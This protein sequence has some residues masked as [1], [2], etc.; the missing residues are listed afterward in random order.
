LAS[1]YGQAGDVPELREPISAAVSMLLA[2]GAVQRAVTA[3]HFGWEPAKHASGHHWPPALLALLLDDPY[4]VV[5]YV[6]AKSLKSYPG[7]A[8]FEYDYIGPE[9]E[10]KQ[11]VDSALRQWRVIRPT[12]A[13]W[14]PAT[15]IDAGGELD[16]QR[17]RR[18][19]RLRNN[20]PIA[21]PE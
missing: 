18:L 9:Q 21:L 10:R 14:D 19:L 3:A 7:F 16:T 4:A 11:A 15:L 20:R 6:A 1:W 5:R 12:G 8:N 17:A 2:G 13:A